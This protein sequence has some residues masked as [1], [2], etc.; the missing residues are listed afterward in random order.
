VAQLAGAV[1]AWLEVK[2]LRIGIVASPMTLR[3][4]PALLAEFL[5]TFALV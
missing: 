2:F 4:G 3:I 5:F 1:V